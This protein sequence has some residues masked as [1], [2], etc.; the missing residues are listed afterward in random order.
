L[1]RHP[2]NGICPYYTMFPIEF[3]LAH[4]GECVPGDWILDPFCGR[5]TTL[6]AA[7][8]LGLNGFGVDAN[9]VAVAISKAKLVGPTPQAIGTLAER[10]IRDSEPDPRP[11]GE[12]WKWAYHPE[13]LRD[14]LRLRVGLRARDGRIASALRG[15]V[16]GALHGP[17]PKHKHSYFS[18]QMQRSFAPKPDYAVRFWRERGLHPPKVDVIAVIRERA[19]RYF[20]EALPSASS[21]LRIGDARRLRSRRVKVRKTITSPPYF[22]MDTYVSD[23]WLRN[24]FV[25]GDPI[26]IYVNPGQISS[27]SPLNFACALGKVW[28]GIARITEGGGELVVRLGALRA[29]AQARAEALGRVVEELRGEGVT[30]ANGLAKALN[31][32]QIATPRGGRW[33]ARSVLNVLQ[34]LTAV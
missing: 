8:L 23:Q 30:S 10:I 33:T 3:P 25:G 20:S 19:V 16:L 5:G 34:R 18:N 22:G 32:R 31:Q 24:W 6:F 7:R 21:G 14:I 29:E 4:L 11:P 2:L 26:P 12:F 9:P 15:V 17:I 27:G 28:Q 1:P 13:T